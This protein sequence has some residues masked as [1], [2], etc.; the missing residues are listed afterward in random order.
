[1]S[2]E[3]VVEMNSTVCE[4]IDELLSTG[5]SVEYAEIEGFK[6]GQKIRIGSVSAGDMIQWSTENEIENMKREAGL[7]LIAKSLV[8][9]N[10]KRYASGDESVVG[11]LRALRH[12]VSERIV[13]EILK[14]NG[15]E[16]KAQNETKKD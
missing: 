10:G 16:V 8:D 14:L 5:T 2:N 4:S 6:P 1:M 9:R 3:K 15:M 11:K 12:N 13:K 7:R